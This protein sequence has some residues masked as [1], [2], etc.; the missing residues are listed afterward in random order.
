MT[1]KETVTALSN[2]RRNTSPKLFM[3]HPIDSSQQTSLL[4]TKSEFFN[5][6]PTLD[7]RQ[8]KRPS[9]S[10]L[11]LLEERS[12]TAGESRLVRRF[13]L[14]R[15]G[16]IRL[17]R[18]QT[19][20]ERGSLLLTLLISTTRHLRKMESNSLPALILRDPRPLSPSITYQAPGFC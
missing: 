2:L 3:I 19:F 18:I 16:G 20:D 11:L 4:Y 7:R 8:R 15:V 6:E 10:R 9:G 17:A 5:E 1:G 14:I 12:T 13:C